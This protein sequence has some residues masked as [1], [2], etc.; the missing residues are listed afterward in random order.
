MIRLPL[1][2]LALLLP[3]TALAQDRRDLEYR[4]VELDEE[5]DDALQVGGRFESAWYEYNNLD[6]RALDEGSDQAI[7]DSDDRGGF[8]FSGAWLDMSY[9]VE[10]GISFVMGASHRGLWGDDQLGNVNRFGGWV[11]LT[12]LYVDLTPGPDSPVSF[13][14][15]RQFYSL[16]GL[17]GGRDF[18]LADTVEMVRADVDIGLGTLELIPVNV[19]SQTDND[20]DGDDYYIY[21]ITKVV[22]IIYSCIDCQQRT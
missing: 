2:A 21:S 10:P 6:F 17:A 11:Y 9:Q 14:I 22:I 1:T 7:L 13:R 8:P 20:G 4:E 19:I 18:V 12:A 3:V 16:G 15:G 5:A